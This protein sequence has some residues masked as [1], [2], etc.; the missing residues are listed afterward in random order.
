[1]LIAFAHDHYVDKFQ[2][3]PR[4]GCPQCS[5]PATAWHLATNFGSQT[6][7]PTLQFSLSLPSPTLSLSVWQSELKVQSV[8]S[9]K[10]GGLLNYEVIWRQTDCRW[11]QAACQAY[12][13]L[14]ELH[15]RK[16]TLSFA[17]KPFLISHFTYSTSCRVPSIRCTPYT[18]YY[19]FFYS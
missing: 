17:R 14:R 8:A 16:K 2:G 10:R 13:L 4:C 15:A 1:M 6:S 3:E 12:N 9:P 7:W 11:D 5:F 18:F 19:Y